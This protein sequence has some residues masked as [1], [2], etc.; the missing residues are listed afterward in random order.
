MQ[1]VHLEPVEDAALD[2]LDQ[3]AGLH[4][5]LVERVAAD[6]DGA[7]EDRVVELARP[8]LVR[9]DRADERAGVQPLAAEDLAVG[10]LVLDRA[11]ERGVGTEL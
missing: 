5:A 3:I 9:A 10:K 6:E 11:R 1:L 2:G 8:R 7:F 4:L